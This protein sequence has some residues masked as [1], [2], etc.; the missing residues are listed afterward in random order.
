[1]TIKDSSGYKVD[2]LLLD[3]IDV[4]WTAASLTCDQSE[5]EPPEAIINV[6]V[7]YFKTG[8]FEHDILMPNLVATAMS[9]PLFCGSRKTTYVSAVLTDTST[10]VSIV[11]SPTDTFTFKLDPPPITVEIDTPYRFDA[12]SVLIDYS[13][14]PA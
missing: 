7:T 11:E 4:T 10:W 1:M 14:V 9:D 8:S 2:E 5:F 13:I 3:N 6:D 12:T